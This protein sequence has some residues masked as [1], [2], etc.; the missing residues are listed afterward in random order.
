MKEKMALVF[1]HV[2]SVL[3]LTLAA[4]VVASFHVMSGTEAL[5]GVVAGSYAFEK[6][7]ELVSKLP[8]LKKE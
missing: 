3:L 6:V 2:A 5:L 7:K 8:G 1:L 4:S